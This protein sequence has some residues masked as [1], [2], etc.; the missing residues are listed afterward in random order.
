MT[1][2]YAKL[3]HELREIITDKIA[4]GDNKLPSESEICKKYKVSRQTCRQALSILMEEKLIE[5]RQGSGTFINPALL[6]DSTK[7][8][9]ILISV[10]N[11]YVYPAL[12]K[13][14]QTGLNKAGY[15]TT[16]HVTG[17]LISAERE[18][19][20]SLLSERISGIIAE[21]VH[22]SLPTPNIDLY[23]RLREIGIPILF[24]NG[25]YPNLKD[26]PYIRSD[27]Y[28]GGYLAA[29]HLIEKS[30]KN[31]C[32]ILNRDDCKGPERYLGITTSL[33][34]YKTPI[35]DNNFIWYTSNDLKRLRQYQ[36]LSFMKD[37]LNKILSDCSA[38]ICQSD[39]IAYFLIKELE[40]N[41]YKIPEDYSV[42]SFDNS[43]LSNFSSIGITGFSHNPHELGSATIKTILKLINK[44]GTTSMSS[45]LTWH[46]VNKSSDSVN[47]GSKL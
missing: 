38:I 43:Y 8:I 2:K 27:D 39:E 21:P 25:S 33:C 41:G 29:K 15:D 46:L 6:S 32:A 31:I 37:Y 11:E 23:E 4:Q 28:Y 35:R 47:P 20:S 22:S 3:A 36:S 34:D 40:K 7:K 42:I 45:R 17:D 9:A 16:V 44:Q 10:S 1:T 13:Y 19:L 5:K 24:F 26:F 12:I 14:L 18:I 30:H